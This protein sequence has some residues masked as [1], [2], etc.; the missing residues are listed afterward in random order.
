MSETRGGRVSGDER[1]DP[2]APA[3]NGVR[4]LGPV[5]LVRAG[6]EVVA[7]PSPTQRRLLA[8]LA[9]QRGRPVRP[10]RLGEDLGLTPGAL[11]KAVSRLRALVGEDALRT[12]P[13]GYVLELDVDAEAFAGAVHA[14]P[15]APDR[16]ATLHA[17][18]ELWHGDAL[19]E[20][21][22]EPWARG[23]ATRL[24]ELR[25]GA[26]EERAALLLAGGRV[27]E[28]VA[29]L[30][31][32][33]VRRPFAD[34]PRLLLMCALAADGRRTEALRSYQAYRS[35]LAE[36]VGTEPSAELQDAERRIAQGWDGRPSV[37]GAP[38]RRTAAVATRRSGSLPVPATRWVGPTA[39]VDATAELLGRCRIV[40]LVGPGGVGKTR[41]A[42]EAAATVADRVSDGVCFV[43]LGAVADPAQVVEAVASTVGSTRQAGLSTLASLVDRLRGR[44]LLLVLDNCEHVSA[45]AAEVV[46]VVGTGC[47]TVTVLA[48]SREPLRVDGEHVV[49]VPA[50]GRVDGAALFT[51]R[52]RAADVTRRF[53][54]D[55]RATIVRICEQ[56]DGIPL[57]L[58]LA[59]ARARTLPL[60]DL[61][62]RLGD[63]LDLLGGG[64]GGLDHQR[65]LRA[66]VDW[67]Y[68]LL[69]E[70]ERVLFE[71]LSVFPGSFDQAA[72]EAVGGADPL[73]ASRV[74]TGLAALVERSMV[75]V[76]RG[77]GG[78]RFRL[79]ETLRT[80]GEERLARRRQ[81]TA[82]GFRHLEHYVGLAEAAAETWF[83]PH[84]LV[85]DAL[86][87]QEW[88]NL[89]AAHA[90]AAA[91]RGLRHAERLLVA[92]IAHSQLRMRTEH[93]SWCH[94][95]VATAGPEPV[96]SA[97]AG[98][99]A[100]WAMVDG[101]HDRAEA[102]CRAAIDAAG[103][104][105]EDDPPDAGLALC[106]SVAAFTAWSSGRREEAAA[107]VAALEAVIDRLPPWPAYTAVRALFSFSTGGEWEARA[108]RIAALCEGIGAPSLVASARFYQATAKLYAGAVP[109][110]ATAA[111]LHEDGIAL[112]RSTGADFSEGQHLQGLL[113]AKVALGS[114]DAAAVCV[115]ALVRLRE[116]GYWLYQWRVLDSAAF[117]L[118][119]AG[120]ADEAA[121]LLGHL[122][123]H[124]PP[125][126]SQPRGGTRALLAG[127]AGTE[128]CGRAGAELDRDD[129]VALAVTALSDVAA[130]PALVAV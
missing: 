54:D 2:G 85:A 129:V 3:V 21:A 26:V 65:T 14:A 123:A 105:P 110:A 23:E 63:R 36:A 119:R 128:R 90:F 116:L 37:T 35:H 34:R 67:S 108:A 103:P 89:R 86:F 80:H 69:D 74:A 102:L 53:S 104:S 61:L 124:A 62:A 30:E 120:R 92:T 1:A 10:E 17:A 112:A 16:L 52:A 75:V 118:A 50:L 64:A 125:W 82:V 106:R 6:G 117:L 88:D 115:R 77:P 93:G 127:H 126:R 66:A 121:T 47:P 111:E 109:D 13:V 96:P 83:G 95:T 98:W 81:T 28:A 91:T 40:T 33:V 100:W 48:T 49:P 8:M 45:A 94:A 22:T 84:Q 4:L 5:A 19:D 7:V 20:F 25:S 87:D 9:L 51:D 29:E 58:E 122:D 56:L 41:S 44:D 99:A 24:D 97:V 18:L 12:G 15:T 38:S 76:E 68:E 70:D 73:S 78:D 72:A 101:A 79:L 57:A 31:R 130:R 55:D 59:A 32:H 60:P 114:D 11:R 39:T 43:E 46:A 107:D 71:R 42:V 27:A 113:D